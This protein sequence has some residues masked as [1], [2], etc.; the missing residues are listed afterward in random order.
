MELPG[1]NAAVGQAALVATLGLCVPP[2][3]VTSIAGPGG[4]RTVIEHDRTIEKYPS[5]YMPENTIRGQLRFA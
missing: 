1:G 5:G 2:P 3:A 4:R